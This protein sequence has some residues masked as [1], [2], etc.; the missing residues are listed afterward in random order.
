MFVPEFLAMP[1]SPALPLRDAHSLDAI[2]DGHVARQRQYFDSGV[3]LDREFRETQLGLLGHAIRKFEPKILAALHDDLRKSSTEAY[4]TEIGFTLSELRH[5]RKHVGKWMRGS[6]WFSPLA[7]GP[8]RSRIHMQPLGLNLIIAPWNYPFQ[9]AI[10]PLVAAIAAGNVA[11]IKPSELAPA[12]SAVVAELVADTFAPEF[13]AV[14]EG[15]IAVA[16]ALL[17]RSWDHIF[18]T[19]SPSVGRIVARAAADQLCRVT[20]ELGGKSPAIVTAT[21]DIEV[22]ARRLAWGKFTNA[23]QTCIAPDYLMVHASVH[24]RVID[25]LREAIRSF[26]GADPRQ[27]ADFGRIVN[28]RHWRRLVGLIDAD[29][30]AIGGNH[31]EDDRYIAPTVLIDVEP[32]DAVMADEIFGPLLPVMRYE[33]LDDAFAI[34][35]RHRNPLAAYLFTADTAEEQRFVEQVSFG[36]G[37]INNTLVHMADPDLPFGGIGTSGLGAYHGRTGFESF[38]H[39]KSVMRTGTFLD[40]SVKYPPY[41]DAKLSIVRK[42]IG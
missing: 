2:V 22:T 9:L 19:G 29:K 24:D 23:G 14:M 39:R 38:S 11:L 16:Q 4:A 1:G 34:I 35:R 40:P 10:A 7:V 26:Y 18:F 8:S 36:G 31:D 12:T 5:T 3:S 42:L 25:A 37:C 13:V 21:A 17:A 33:A 6:S 41:T 28:A 20:L 27:S 30:V 15:E 32:D